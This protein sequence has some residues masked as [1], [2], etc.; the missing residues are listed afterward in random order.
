MLPRLLIR[1]R[2]LILPR[3]LML[4]QLKAEAEPF[5]GLLE[6]LPLLVSVVVPGSTK[7]RVAKLQ[8]E[9]MPIFMKKSWYDH[10]SEIKS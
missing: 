4:K 8:K 5:G 9:V 1:P 2:L 10:D 7:R 3:L 6:F